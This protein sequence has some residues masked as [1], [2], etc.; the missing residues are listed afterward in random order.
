MVCFQRRSVAIAFGPVIEPLY[1]LGFTTEGDQADGSGLGREDAGQF[2]EQAR[3]IVLGTVK[4]IQKADC[5]HA[6]CRILATVAHLC[7]QVPGSTENS[8]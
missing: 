3:L 6:S 1:R 7:K 8:I 2:I 4:G 5:I